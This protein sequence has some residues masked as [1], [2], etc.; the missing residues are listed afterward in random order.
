MP[1]DRKKRRPK[2]EKTKFL[3]VRV[4]H[5]PNELEYLL[6]FLQRENPK[7]IVEIGT[8]RGGLSIIL[9]TWAL[10]NDAKVI[11][12]DIKKTVRHRFHGSLLEILGIELIT[13]DAWK[14]QT[15]TQIQEKLVPPVFIYCDGGNKVIDFR[16]YAPL[17]VE[18]DTIAAHDTR[19]NAIY[20][21]IVLAAEEHGLTQ[22]GRH[23]RITVFKKWKEQ[24][25]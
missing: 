19:N 2:P 9:G 10:K 13:G 3:G 20:R 16:T 12:V 1:K 18:G 5:S 23:R 14:P 11:T 25:Q 21:K 7:T 15:V 24:L 17:L 4:Q 6:G 22:I 8:A